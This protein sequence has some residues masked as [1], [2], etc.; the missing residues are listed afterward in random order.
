[1]PAISRSELEREPDGLLKETT[2]CWMS[3]GHWTC[4]TTGGRG[5]VPPNQTP[6]ALREE[7][8]QKPMYLG[9]HMTSSQQCDGHDARIC[10]SMPKLLSAERGT[11]FD[12]T[13]IQ[14]W[15]GQMAE[16]MGPSSP[17]LADIPMQAC[18]SLLWSCSRSFLGTFV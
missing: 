1:M 3:L 16:S 8:L 10:R 12:S 17:Q 11:L 18:H 9:L 6:P 4:Q 15:E 14:C 7:A 5:Q 13:G 2:D